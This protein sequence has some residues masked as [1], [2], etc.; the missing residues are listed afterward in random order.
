MT[1][2]NNQPYFVPP[3]YVGKIKPKITKRT[4]QFRPVPWGRR[5]S[6]YNWV[7]AILAFLLLIPLGF[8]VS[9]FVNGR[10]GFGFGFLLIFLFLGG[11]AFL[12]SWIYTRNMYE[13]GCPYCGQLLPRHRTN[14]KDVNHYLECEHCHEWLISHQGTVRAFT[15]ADVMPNMEF[16]T[17]FFRPLKWPK[18]C[19][20]CGRQATRN[21][22]IVP[23]SVGGPPGVN[24]SAR[25]T[26]NQVRTKVPYCNDHYNSVAVTNFDGNP[27]LFFLDFDARRRLLAL[28]KKHQAL[29]RWDL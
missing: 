11:M 24:P 14:P 27:R 18:E 13:T 15:H 17:P 8:G 2:Y 12:L 6:G 21:Q 22:D 26:G 28:N 9:H 16:S 5:F 20:V 19:I 4:L 3:P 10:P 29:G 25:P 23:G 7:V 1:Y